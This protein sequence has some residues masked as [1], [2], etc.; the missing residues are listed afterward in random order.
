MLVVAAFS[1][2]AG[3]LSIGFTVLL[4]TIVFALLTW[5][6]WRRSKS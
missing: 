2:A 1:F 4:T 3:E 6:M 5:H